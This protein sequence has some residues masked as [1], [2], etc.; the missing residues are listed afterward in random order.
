MCLPLI[1]HFE[2]HISAAAVDLVEVV[3]EVTPV[4]ALQGEI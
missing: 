4:V 1:K 3:S 2:S